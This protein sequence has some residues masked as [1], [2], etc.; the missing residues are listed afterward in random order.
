MLRAKYYNIAV[1]AVR[2]K[3]FSSKLKSSFHH[4]PAYPH[5]TKMNMYFFFLIRKTLRV[6]TIVSCGIYAVNLVDNST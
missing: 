1:P 6:S 2:I 3:R 4:Y 5:S